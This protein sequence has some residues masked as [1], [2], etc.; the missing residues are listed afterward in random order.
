[1]CRDR[2]CVFILITMMVSSSFMLIGC[3]KDKY[4][5]DATKGKGLAD[6]GVGDSDLAQVG[7][8]GDG[9]IQRD[10]GEVC[11]EV[12]ISKLCE[13]GMKECMVCEQCQFVTGEPGLSHENIMK[14]AA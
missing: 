2:T 8:C 12:S 4:Y 11:D 9:I 14:Q 6:M 13:Y 10:L 1:M 5:Y 7:Y 3:P